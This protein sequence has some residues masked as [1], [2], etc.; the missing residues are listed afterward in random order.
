MINSSYTG[1]VSKHLKSKLRKDPNSSFI[2][3][4]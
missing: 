3:N 2:G 1:R 4:K